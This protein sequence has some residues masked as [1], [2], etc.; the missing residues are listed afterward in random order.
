VCKARPGQVVGAAE[1]SPDTSPDDLGPR[2]AALWKTLAQSLDTVPGQIALEACRT[3][4]RLED[5]DRVIRGKGV[6]KMM[7][8]RLRADWEDDEKRDVR[9]QVVFDQVLAE[10]RMQ[11]ASFAKLLADVGAPA[12]PLPKPKA[13]NPLDELRA[14]REAKA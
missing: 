11:Q 4:D 14:K 5:M 12:V 8:Y 1:R 3:A 10:A 13:K 7:Q 6:L 9:V 2:G